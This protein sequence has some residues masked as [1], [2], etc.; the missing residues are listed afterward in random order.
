MDHGS[1]QSVVG[2]VA[3]DNPDWFEMKVFHSS[4]HHINAKGSITANKVGG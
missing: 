3:A 1:R 2:I 4:D